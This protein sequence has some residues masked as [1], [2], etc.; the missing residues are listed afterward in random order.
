MTFSQRVVSITQDKILPKVTDNYLSDNFA[1]F[2]FISNGSAWSGETLKRPVKLSKNTLGGSFSGLDEHS[3]S[4][5]NTRQTMSYDVRAY[6][7][8]VAVPGLERAVNQTDAQVLNLVRVELES[9]MEDALDDTGDMFYGDGTGN[10][11]KDFNGLGNLVD[12]GTTAST[13][14][15]LSRTTYPTLAGTRTASGGTMT[16]NK[17]GTLISAVSAGSSARQRPTLM[18]SNETVW[19]LAE[20]LLT[21]TVQSN[22]EANG[23]PMVTR[24]SR[25]VMTAASLKGAQ[26]FVSIVLRGIPY[27]G[28]EKSTSQT[29]WAVNENYLD[30][31]GLKDS[32]LKSIS[33]GAGANI[34]G[35]YAEPPTENTGLQWTGFLQPTNVYGKVAHVYLLGNLV[36]FQ[37]RRHGRLTG[38]TGV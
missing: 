38:I 7:I 10:D 21:P 24:R 33:L 8:P 28:D 14:G 15:N 16:L 31:Y 35:V 1:T 34:D 13:I 37:P 5:V 19:D 12:D 17:I 2:R 6:E 27:V 32:E 20:S 4:T 11:S 26:G 22:Y 18:I 29:L 23:F 3:T 9:S 25:G 36:T 30:W